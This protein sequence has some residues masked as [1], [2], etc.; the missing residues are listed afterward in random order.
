MNH[1][2]FAGSADDAALRQPYLL[3]LG[4][5][6]DMLAAK[7][8]SGI[9][10]WRPRACLGQLRLPGCAADVGLADIDLETAA[11]SGARTLVIGVAARGGRI[12]QSWLPTLVRAL[13]LDFDIAAGLHERVGDIEVLRQ[14]ASKRNRRLIDVRH[15]QGPFEIA[16]GDRRP[17]KRVL[18]VG[19][20]CS[21]GKMFTALALEAEMRGRG[22][23]VDFRA[24]G[25]TGI[26]IAG[27][28][29]CIDGV[30][31]DFVAGAVE[32]LSPANRPDHWDVIEGQASVLHPSYAGVTLGL[33]HGS[34]PDAMVLCHPVQRPY[35]RGLGRRPLPDLRVCIEAHE[36]AARLTNPDAK[37][38]GLSLNT[39]GVAPE[40]L[41]GLL[42][43]YED[44][45]GLPA[46]D[47]LRTGA[48][49]LVDALTGG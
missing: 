32:A 47:P 27:S 3:F 9:A 23:D 33:V 12:P 18:T 5:A 19:T 7:T 6:P 15:P 42:A 35:M 49:R 45:Y 28:G 39:T 8:A 44:R 41:S 21:A 37:V 11:A 36:D 10:I 30:I 38:I 43:G 48:G 31:S 13:E 22:I 29:I 20:D 40:A 24:T 16:N 2:P 34:Q 17:G 25:Q 46:V 4:D 14:A 1:R 26:L